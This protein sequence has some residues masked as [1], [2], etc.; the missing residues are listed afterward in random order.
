MKIDKETQTN[1]NTQ[2]IPEETS[3]ITQ[4][5]MLIIFPRDRLSQ[6]N[7]IQLLMMTIIKFL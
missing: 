4:F 7:F 1:S 3:Q 2:S 5:K 6:D